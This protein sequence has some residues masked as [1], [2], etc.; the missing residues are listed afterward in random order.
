MI[1][2]MKNQSIWSQHPDYKIDIISR[3]SEISISFNGE[4]IAQSQHTLLLQEQDHQPVVYFPRQ[5]VRME[6]LHSIA[7]TSF[8]PFKGN[9]SYWSLDIEGH[10]IE[11]AAWSYEDPFPEMSRIK[12]YIAFYPEV[13]SNLKDT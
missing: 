7:K 9:A 10:Q 6:L 11:M 13:F 1:H 3:D 8:C 12:N 2:K 5:N 4:L